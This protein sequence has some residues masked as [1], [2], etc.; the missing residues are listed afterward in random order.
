M[1]FNKAIEHVL[2]SEG[3][4]T[5][6]PDDDGNWTGS[7]KGKGILKGTKWGISAAS[8]PTLDIFNLTREEAIVIYKRDFW[9][10]YKIDQ[11]PNYIQL[12]F[13]DVCVNSGYSRAVRILQGALGIT[14]D[15]DFGPATRKALPRITLWKYTEERAD[16]YVSIVKS[17]PTKIKYLTGWILR[18][19]SVTEHSI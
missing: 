12:H 18:V 10:K 16:F 9:D 14:I 2:S 5:N 7:K 4:F 1:N 15:G 17:N 6:D 19:L 13:F 3:G 8:Y 11:L